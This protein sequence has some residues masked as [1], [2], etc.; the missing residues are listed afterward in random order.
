MEPSFPNH[1]AELQ[2]DDFAGFYARL[3]MAMLW[4]KATV[5]R[6]AE[7]AGVAEVRR[8]GKRP[9]ANLGANVIP[10]MLRIP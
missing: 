10:A 8:G 1:K 5:T 2:A 4:A 6:P 3:A 9:P 7:A